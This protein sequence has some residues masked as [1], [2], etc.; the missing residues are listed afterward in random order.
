MDISQQAVVRL[1]AI[2]WLHRAGQRD[3]LEDVRQLY[4]ER[5]CLASIGAPAWE[6]VTLEARNEI[7]GYLAARSYHASSGWNVLAHV[8]KERLEK[9]VFP[10]LPAFITDNRLVMNSV[11]WDLHAYLM[12]DA[13]ASKL[14]KPLFFESLVRIYE[15]G[16]IP[17]GWGGEWP[18][19]KLMI[20]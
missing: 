9:E 3:A 20:Y 10:H 18:D 8:A 15:A 5:D 11:E 16:H 17:C 13:Y 14:K 4:C 7:T 6:D 2:R 1:Q 19:G 12:E